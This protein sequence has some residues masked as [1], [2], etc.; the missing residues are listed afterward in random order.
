VA[1]VQ[2]SR[3]RELAAWMQIHRT[4][5]YPSAFVSVVP[6]ERERERGRETMMMMMMM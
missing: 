6:Y 4:V 3:L 2:L 5:M 1:E